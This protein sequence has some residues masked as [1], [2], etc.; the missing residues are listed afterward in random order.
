MATASPAWGCAW[1]RAWHGSTRAEGRSRVRTPLG[2]F[3]TNFPL[4]WE[5]MLFVAL[6]STPNL[7]L[8]GGR[9]RRVPGGAME[10]STSFRPDLILDDRWNGQP[11]RLVLDAKDYVEDELPKGEAVR[12]QILYRLLLSDRTK[13]GQL[14]LDRIGNGFLAPAQVAEGLRVTA[15]HDIEGQEDAAA[16]LGRIVCMDVDFTRVATA[17]ARGRVDVGLRAEIIAATMSR[18]ERA[19]AQGLRTCASLPVTGSTTA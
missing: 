16:A 3:A 14:P 1:L 12:K 19:S 18:Q 17:Y 9:Y 11:V 5:R 4:V 2:V 15:V 13:T 10:T 6:G 7:D 8:P